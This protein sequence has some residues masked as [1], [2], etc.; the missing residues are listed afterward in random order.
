MNIFVTD[1]DP[2]ISARNLCDK[3]VPKMIVESAQMLSTVHRMLDGIPE[4]RPSKSGKTTQTYYSFGDERDG[5]YYLAVHKFHPCTVWTR[6]SKA[7]YVW[8]YRHFKAMAEEYQF[9]RNKI[10]ATYQK[11]GDLLAKPPQNISDVGLTEF[12]QAMN[13]Y[14]DCKVSGDAVTAYRKY[15]HAAKPF[16]KWEWKR[17]AP[18]W[19]QGFEGYKGSH[20]DWFKPSKPALL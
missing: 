18:S 3:H 2:V 6:E 8:H 10:H 14:P 12:A 19:W 13:H 20:P 7:N 17:P 16:A 1:F 4:K 11:L 5:L 9:R 15:Y